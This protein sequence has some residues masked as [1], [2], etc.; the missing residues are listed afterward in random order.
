MSALVDDGSGA[1][2]GREATQIG[3]TLLGHNHMHIV[4]GV[5]HMRNHRHNARNSAT[6]G[7]RRRHEGR[8]IGV[9][10]KVARATNAV[11][12]A[13][14]HDVGGIDVTVH[15][16]LN[17]AVHRQHAQAADNF[18]VVTDFLRTQQDFATQGFDVVFE[19]FQRFFT[20]ADGCR[21]STDQLARNNHIEHTV[22]QH[23]GVGRKVLERTFVQTSQHSVGDIAHARLQ[24]QQVFGQ[25]ASLD[26]VGVEI[27]QMRSDF[28]RLGIGWRKFG[29]AVAGVGFN[30]GHHFGGVHAHERA[31]NAVVAAQQ[32]NGLAVRRHQCSVV[33]NVV[34]ALQRHALVA[35]YFQNYLVGQLQPGVVVANGC[36]RHERAIFENGGNFNNGYSHLAVKAKAGVLRYVREV[37]I[38]VMHAA[39]VDFFAA[40]GV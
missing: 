37:N 34:H 23:F 29:I 15:I 28:F 19:I 27:Q 5:V 24:R 2:L 32:W 12:D 17:H 38:A 40:N 7:G 25:A 30:H 21:R 22:L 13:C 20:Q 33:V 6:L 36:R 39:F 3:Q 26:F 4:L 31:A 16:G 35:V 8:D 10:G 18:G 14:A 9:A 11:H 1:L